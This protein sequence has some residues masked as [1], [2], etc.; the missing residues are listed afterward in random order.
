METGVARFVDDMTKAGFDIA[1]EAEV[2][3]FR[4]T[5]VDGAHA[6]TPVDTG[7]SSDELDPWPQAP[8]HWVHFADSVGFSHT[9]PQ[10]SPKSGWLMH[11]RDLAGWGDAPPAV[12]WASHVRAVLGEAIS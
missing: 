3:T 1:V 7:V 6:G 10:P 11:S 12:C 4:I 2:V 9:N 8:P 5:P